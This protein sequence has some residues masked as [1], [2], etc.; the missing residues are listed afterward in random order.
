MQQPGMPGQP[1]P[2]QQSAFPPNPGYAAQPQYQE[3]SYGGGYGRKPSYKTGLGIFIFAIA[4]TVFAGGFGLKVTIELIF[5]IAAIS[6][7]G[8]YSALNFLFVVYKIGAIA[9][10]LGILA[11]VVAAVFCMLSPQP[12]FGL[13]IGL[14]CVAATGAVMLSF[15]EV[16]PLLQNSMDLLSLLTDP[17]VFL[18]VRWMVIGTFLMG[19]IYMLYA[20]KSKKLR[21]GGDFPKWSIIG[22]SVCA[23]VITLVIILASS[24]SDLG[25]R[26]VGGMKAFTYFIG[27]LYFVS[28]AAMI[29]GLVFLI[30][31]LFDAKKHFK[32]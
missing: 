12:L 30:R 9:R 17:F 31:C 19:A 11:T 25:I 15:M 5:A 14:I 16:I 23:G 1:F 24:F 20:L 7:A 22:F 21:Y 28:H 3:P 13:G 27:M 4:A 18:M 8:L 32:I 29:I 10:M 26:S 6:G 2:P